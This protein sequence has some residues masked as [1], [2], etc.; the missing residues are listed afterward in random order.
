[1]FSTVVGELLNDAILTI[2]T[3]LYTLKLNLRSREQYQ[4]LKIPY[5]FAFQITKI[6]DR[7]GK[8]PDLP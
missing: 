4:A 1:M 2:C 7:F 8:Y 6:I 3:L 5:D